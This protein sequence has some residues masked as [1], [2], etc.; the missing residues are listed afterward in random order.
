MAQG[1][2]SLKAFFGTYTG[3]G[4]ADNKDSIYFGVTA[5]DLDVVIHPEGSGFSVAWTTVAHE[6]GDPAKPKTKRKEDRVVFVPGAAEGI[7]RAAEEPDP[8]SGNPYVWA[9]IEGSSLFVYLLTVDVKG[10]YE[11]QRYVRTISGS[12]MEL[13][14]VAEREG[15]RTRTVKGKL[16]RTGN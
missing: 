15:E 14:F 5:R 9:R 2:L 11:M 1:T 8:L 4:V 3:S 16:S 12:G 7:W 10:R 13:T 6:G